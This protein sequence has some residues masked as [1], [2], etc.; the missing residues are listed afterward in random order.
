VTTFPLWI[1]RPRRWGEIIAGAVLL[2]VTLSIAGWLT[3]NGSTGVIYA[4][5]LMLLVGWVAIEGIQSSFVRRAE[6]QISGQELK[7]VHD[8]AFA[9]SLHVPLGAIESVEA[10]RAPDSRGE[11]WAPPTHPVPALGIDP[12]IAL[13]FTETRRLPVRGFA[14]SFAPTKPDGRSAVKPYDRVAGLA[15]ALD[16]AVDLEAAIAA[17]RSA[18][19][20]LLGVGQDGEVVASEKP[21][22]ETRSRAEVKE[23]HRGIKTLERRGDVDALL[24]LVDDLDPGIRGAAI[25]ALPTTSRRDGALRWRDATGHPESIPALSERLAEDPSPTVR[26]AAALALDLVD[27]PAVISPLVGA[28]RDPKPRVRR[29]AIEGLRKRQARQAVEDL[30][31]LVRV[32]G[33]E[34][35]L[36]GRALVDIRDERALAPLREAATSADTR[37]E[38]RRFGEMVEQLERDLGYG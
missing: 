3:T 15:I 28:L 2:L 38:R 31:E 24:A 1:H 4:L 13:Y 18:G 26:A 35:L 33:D 30:I 32:R 10:L 29:T 11:T 27:D 21:S 6:L 9:R 7:V 20:S 5:G 36:A 8:G 16:P 14:N 34:S 37:R 12:D 17:L 25:L 23:I 22:V 19:V